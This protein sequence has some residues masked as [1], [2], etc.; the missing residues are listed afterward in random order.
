MVDEVLHQSHVIPGVV[1]SKSD[2]IAAKYAVIGYTNPYRQSNAKDYEQC[3]SIYC[4]RGEPGSNFHE[5]TAHSLKI[6]PQILAERKCEFHGRTV[7][8]SMDCSPPCDG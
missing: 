7:T 5:E 4:L 2:P 1:Y 8:L 3:Y 6:L